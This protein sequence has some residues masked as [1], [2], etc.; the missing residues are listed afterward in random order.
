[1]FT[2]G[3]H[4][5]LGFRVITV[6]YI[7]VG[8]GSVAVEA[9]PA[10]PNTDS[11]SGNDLMMR[12]C[13]SNTSAALVTEIPGKVGHSMPSGNDDQRENGRRKHAANHRDGDALH[14]FGAGA[15]RF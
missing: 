7:S 12:S 3:R 10:L 11:T 9:R 15:R 1:M 8:A 13:I 5:C 14:D 4:S 6:S 2:P